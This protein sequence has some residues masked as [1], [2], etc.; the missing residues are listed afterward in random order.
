[1]QVYSTLQIGEFHTNY[2]E[3]FLIHEQIATDEKL[4]AVMDGCTMGKESVF[5]SILV[6]K[7][8]RNIA[9]HYYYQEFI[10]PNKIDLKYKLKPILE[11]LFEELKKLKNQLG[12][13]IEELL[14]TLLI[15]LIDEKTSQAEFLCLGDGFI[16]Y[17]GKTL[18]FEQENKPDYLGYHLSED[19]E[20]FYAN[21]QQRLSLNQFEDLSICTDGIFTFQSLQK[22]QSPKSESDIIEFLLEDSQ[23]DQNDN[24]LDR[25]MRILQEEYFIAPTDDLA[26]IR[27]KNK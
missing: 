12:L 14:T 26:I 7:V 18:E 24:F 6:G 17:D 23:F 22:M 9:K 10:S 5:A 27:I 4:V 20:G 13:E 25:K 11:R 21:Q 3:D 2:C 19:F 8:L 1:M 15:A 16:F